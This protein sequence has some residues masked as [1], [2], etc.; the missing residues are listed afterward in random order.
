MKWTHETHH[1]WTARREAIVN[2]PHDPAL[3]VGRHV[4]ITQG[5]HRYSGTVTSAEPYKA[6]DGL[7]LLFRFDDGGPE[8]WFHLPPSATVE[9]LGGDSLSNADESTVNPETKTLAVNLVWLAN[10]R[11]DL[12]ERRWRKRRLPSTSGIALAARIDTLDQVIKHGTLAPANAVEILETILTQHWD[13]GSCPC[14]VCVEARAIGCRPREDY[15]PGHG[16]ERPTVR[17]EAEK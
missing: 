16:R 4:C 15:L 13:L 7:A 1:K 12:H 14:W 10:Y 5:R 9:Q 8:G 6:T 11:K 2:I 17:V 3:L